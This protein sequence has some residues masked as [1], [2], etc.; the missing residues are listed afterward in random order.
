MKITYIE[1]TSEPF[2]N[3][4]VDCT[5]RCGD[6]ELHQE[7]PLWIF[8][9]L[10]FNKFKLVHSP[11]FRTPSYSISGIENQALNCL[12][13]AWKTNGLRIFHWKIRRQPRS[14][15]SDAVGIIKISRPSLLLLHSFPYLC[16]PKSVIVRF[17]LLPLARGCPMGKPIFKLKTKG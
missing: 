11:I 6:A 13:R 3:I 8:V 7:L 17:F 4:F 2:R 14:N 15:R 1:L 16:D 12:I 10:W 9:S 5:E